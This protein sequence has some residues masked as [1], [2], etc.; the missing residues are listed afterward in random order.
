MSVDVKNKR[1]AGYSL[2]ELMIVV[3][4]IAVLL[5][6]ISITYA[7]VGKANAKSYATTL[8]Q[9]IA[10]AQSDTM[11]RVQNAYDLILTC[12]AE[13][14]VFAQVGAS[15]QKHQIGT[16]KIPVSITSD[17]A[18]VDMIPGRQFTMT[19]SKSSGKVN[20]MTFGFGPA[21]ASPGPLMFTCGIDGGKEYH[22]F[23]VKQTGK[24]YME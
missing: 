8:R 2:V 10:A 6:V 17:G 9:V 20:S 13:G 18:N 22:V 21:F 1:N 5:G 15:G 14:D 11:G 7:V 12:D 4:I 3:A 24:I 19:F 16:S 23:V